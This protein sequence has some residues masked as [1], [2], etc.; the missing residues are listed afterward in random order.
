MFN[1]TECRIIKIITKNSRDHLS[2]KLYV[3]GN[4]LNVRHLFII[5][6]IY[7]VIL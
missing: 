6:T 5:K 1:V 3:D 7:F 4:T 2:T